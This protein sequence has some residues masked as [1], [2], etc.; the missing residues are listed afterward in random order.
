MPAISNNVINCLA[1]GKNNELWLG[2]NS[3]FGK[4]D[5]TRSQFNLIVNNEFFSADNFIHDL[6]LDPEDGLWISSL[7]NLIRMNLVASPFTAFKKS[8]DGKTRMNPYPR[9]LVP[10]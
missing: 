7:T 3:G 10:R 2:T 6:F 9:P 4:L 1:A 5:L 8:A